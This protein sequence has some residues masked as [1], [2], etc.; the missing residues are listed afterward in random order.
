MSDLNV[1][2]F[3]QTLEPVTHFYLPNKTQSPHLP[4]YQKNIEADIVVRLT[5]VL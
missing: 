3:F 1:D 5:G 4:T 2:T